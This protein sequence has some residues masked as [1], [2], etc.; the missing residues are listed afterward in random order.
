MPAAVATFFEQPT[1][2]IVILG[3]VNGHPRVTRVHTPP[4]PAAFFAVQRGVKGTM[5]VVQV[6]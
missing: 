1:P 5:I 4:P 2:K 3:K 6:E